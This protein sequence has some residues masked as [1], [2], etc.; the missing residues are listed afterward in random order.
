MKAFRTKNVVANAVM[1]FIT[2][3]LV[4]KKDKN[5]LINVKY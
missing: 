4:D 2:S 5:T 1:T 3:Q